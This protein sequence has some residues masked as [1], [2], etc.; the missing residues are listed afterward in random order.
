MW[1]DRKVEGVLVS[2]TNVLVKQVLV[3]HISAEQSQSQHTAF[4]WKVFF[5]SSGSFPILSCVRTLNRCSLQCF[6]QFFSAQASTVTQLNQVGVFREF[7]QYERLIYRK[8]PAL[9][10]LHVFTSKV[11]SAV[12]L[13]SQVNLLSLSLLAAASHSEPVQKLKIPPGEGNRPETA[14]T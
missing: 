6:H 10:L 11:G 1:V 8:Y 7:T 2:R 14:T 3:A 12:L 5:R 9:Q 4:I 13:F